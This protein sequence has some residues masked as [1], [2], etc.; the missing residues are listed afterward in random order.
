MPP[1]PTAHL[2]LS[3]L[4]FEIL[5]SL[6]RRDLHGYAIAAEIADRTGG[7]LAPGMSSLYLAIRRL[8]RNGFVADGGRHDGESGGPPR[9]YYH[10]TRRGREVAR[11]EARRLQAQLR[12][13]AKVFLDS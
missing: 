11:L 12:A 10:I 7:A 6:G 4:D 2:P 3:A 5:V 8:V 1:D 9:R 13:A